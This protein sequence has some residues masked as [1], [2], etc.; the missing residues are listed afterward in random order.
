MPLSPEELL[1]QRRHTSQWDGW[2]PTR[3]GKG[4]RPW[5]DDPGTI[6][7]RDIA[8]GL[9][10]TYRYGGQS[11]PAIT[12]AEHSDLVARI[13]DILWPG[14]PELV[15]AALL[16]DAAESVLHDIQ[17]PLRSRVKVHLDNQVLS[18]DQS[19]LRVTQQIAAQFGV[20]PEHLNAPEVRAADILSVCL[21][22]RD[23]KNLSEGDWGLPEMPEEITALHM[24]FLAPVSAEAR[25]FLCARDLGIR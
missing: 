11:D 6:S 19:D 20:L 5:S 12:V 16:H 1:N 21:E 18:W 4:Y 2:V 9:A 13:L 10:H 17:G 24:S 15:R 8:Y 3:S 22:R 25:F 7:L 14:K 23:C